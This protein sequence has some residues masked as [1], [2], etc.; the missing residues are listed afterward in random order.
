MLKLIVSRLPEV[1]RAIGPLIGVVCLWQFTVLEA[2]GTF[3]DKFVAL[4]YV[5]T[6][7]AMW[8]SAQ[9]FE[10]NGWTPPTTWART[11]TR[12]KRA[13]ASTPWPIW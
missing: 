9:L 3:G 13:R 5:M 1:L 8:Y 10:D 11:A 12:R 2:P 6:V 7:Y 4:N